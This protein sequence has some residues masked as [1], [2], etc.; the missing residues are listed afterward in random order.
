MRSYSL[1]K[2]RFSKSG[3]INKSDSKPKRSCLF[4]KTNSENK[5]Y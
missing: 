1:K 5:T 4:N 3:L 2:V